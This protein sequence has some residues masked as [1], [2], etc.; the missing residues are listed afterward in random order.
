VLGL[1]LVMLAA[2]AA[3]AADPEPTTP[4]EHFVVL[5]QENHTFDNYFAS[6]PGAD[7][8]PKNVC[9]PKVVTD[10]SAGCDNRVWIG[11]TPTLDLLHSTEVSAEQLNGG[12]MNGFVSAFTRRGI[13]AAQPMGYYDD[14]DLP[15]YWN[16]A[17]SYVL[18]DRFFTP[19]HAGSVWNHMF[20]VTGAAGNPKGDVIPPGG[21]DDKQVPTIF[22]RLEAAGVSWKFYVQNYDPRITAFN[23][24]TLTDNDKLSQPIWVPLLAYRKYVDDP[25]LFSHIVDMSQYY[26]DAA[27]GTLP[28]VS[29]MAPAGSSEHPPGRI[30]AGEAFIR[31]IV[32]ALMRSSAWPSSAFMWTYD[33]WGGWYDHVRPPVVD[34]YGYGFRV[35]AILVSSWARHGQVNHTQ[36]DFTSMLKFIEENWRLQPLA[37][38]DRAAQSIA[39][40]FDFTRQAPRQ[41]VLLGLE[42]HVKPQ[43]PV[44]TGLI[45]WLYGLAVLLPLVL[46]GVAL[47]ARRRWRRTA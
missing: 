5:M 23:T 13:D 36:L 20:W 1:L 39:S 11:N 25:K 28:A 16:L 10:P 41:P 38:R 44:R 15:Y 7:G 22:D 2:P 42:R 46:I 12:K 34:Q 17:D 24:R 29:F 31:T 32:T 3:R 43:P 30:Q 33:D 26:E 14:R 9:M 4:I 45:Y 6:Y 47:T 19:A 27:N 35:P 40:A 8:P 37:A 18:F 21:F